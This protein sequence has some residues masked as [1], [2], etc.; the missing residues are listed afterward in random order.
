[1]AYKIGFLIYDGVAELDF[2]GPKDVFFASSYLSHQNDHLYTVA[3]TKTPVTCVGGLKVVPDHDFATAPLPD[4][5]VVPG[6]VDP[7][8]QLADPQLLAWVAAADRQTT[9]TTG[10]CTGSLILTAAGPAKGRRIT[11][12][13]SVIEALR[14]QNE[15]I[16]VDN[17]RYVVDGKLCNQRR[18]QCRYRHGAVAGWS[19]T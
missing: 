12:H 19:A 1:V 11:S 5:L 14:A 4:I 18:S 2:V 8:P 13:W 15:A 9:W 3:A 17:E 6:A 7:S 16:V 10:V